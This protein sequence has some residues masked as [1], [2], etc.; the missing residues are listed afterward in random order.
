M[1]ESPCCV[2][3]VYLS[4]F[5]YDHGES[6]SLYEASAQIL[7][8]LNGDGWKNQYNMENKHLRFRAGPETRECRILYFTGIKSVFVQ[9]RY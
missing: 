9:L 1:A 6:P 8:V 4:L 7:V 2:R 5:V 3:H